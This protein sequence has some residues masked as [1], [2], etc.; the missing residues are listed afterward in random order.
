MKVPDGHN[1]RLFDR[2]LAAKVNDI[3]HCIHPECDKYPITFLQRGV[4]C[5]GA[6][7]K[8]GNGSIHGNMKERQLWSTPHERPRNI[9][10]TFS[11]ERYEQTTSLILGRF[12]SVEVKGHKIPALGAK[13][14]GADEVFIYD[15][16]WLIEQTNF[17]RKYDYLFTQPS[18][19]FG[20]FAWK[21]FIILDALSRLNDGDVVL[22]TD[23]DTFPI[24]DLTWFY[25]QCRKEGGIFLFGACGESNRFWNKR[26]CMILCGMDDDKWRDKPAAVARFMLFEKSKRSIEFMN[27]WLKL[28]TDLRATTFE[29]STL[30][31]EYPDCIQHR[32]EQ[33]ILTNLAH[34][35]ELP[36]HREACEAGLIHAEKKPRGTMPKI[37]AVQSVPRWG[38]LDTQHCIA[39]G[40][41]AFGIKSTKHHGA[42]WEQGVQNLLED[43]IADGYEFCV[44]FD[45]DSMFEVEDLGVMLETILH[46]KNIDILSCV[47]PKRE[48][49]IMMVNTLKME[50]GQSKEID[51]LNPMPITSAHFGL[52]VIRLSFLAN[53]PKPWFLNVPN[54][55]GEWRQGMIPADMYFWKKML[56]HGVKSF[57]LPCVS[58]GHTETTVAKF[59][60][61]TGQCEYKYIHEWNKKD[62][63]VL[64]IG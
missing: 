5:L 45:F 10:M 4:E 38:P 23:A 27:L 8:N 15:D 34:K 7:M 40:C 42:W 61:K 53:I 28:A 36:L 54:D 62:A 60:I 32:C 30:A 48:D 19:G 50:T 29:D 56:D 17:T 2:E 14:Y 35:W 57:I 31:K 13:K 55:K 26:D 59:N 3:K 43:A 18:H 37:I 58:I 64:K 25:D 21:P 16:K 6:P 9:Y 22:Y 33:S 47:Q 11:G 44:A 1:R 51:L 39:M 41:A 52:T 49:G 12:N 46:N 24:N 20:W 63:T